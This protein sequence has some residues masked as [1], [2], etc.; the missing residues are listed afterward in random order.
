VGGSFDFPGFLD[1][2]ALLTNHAIGTAEAKAAYRRTFLACGL[3]ISGGSTPSV[4]DS[5]TG[6][7]T[8]ISFKS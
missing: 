6:L 3:G 2:R 8:R 4:G 1:L 5:A 7:P